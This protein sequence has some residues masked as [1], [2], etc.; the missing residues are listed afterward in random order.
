[1][2]EENWSGLVGSEM[3]VEADNIRVQVPSFV[4]T[5]R[6]QTQ[7]RPEN[8]SAPVIKNIP[9]VLKCFD[10]ICYLLAA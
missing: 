9:H 2:I 1:M 7:T 4:G 10:N 5:G 8:V 6:L 3:N